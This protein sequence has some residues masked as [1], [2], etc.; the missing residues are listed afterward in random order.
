MFLRHAHIE[1]FR[2]IARLDINFDDTTVL[3]GENAAG[4][5]S[6]LEALEICLGH[7]NQGN[8]FPFEPHD[9]NLAGVSDGDNPPDIRVCVTF[10]ERA[11]GEWDAHPTLATSFVDT[12]A[13]GRQLTLEVS[14]TRGGDEVATS[15]QFLDEH[16]EAMTP[17]PHPDLVAT[18]RNLCPFLLVR[19]DR[20]AAKQMHHETTPPPLQRDPERA[21]ER[22]ISRI[23]DEII[24]SDGLPPAEDLRDGIRNVAKLIAEQA[25]GIFEHP[26]AP[27]LAL[28]ELVERP[29]VFSIGSGPELEPGRH[30]AGAGS[31]AL[32]LLLGAVLEARGPAAAAPGA[33]MILAIEEPE[34]HLHPLML[35]AMWSVIDSLR[36]QKMVTSN[37]GELLSSAR[38]SALRRLVRRVDHTAVFQLGAE[39]LTLDETR[40]VTYHLRLRHDNAL[41]ARA[42]LLV[43]GET[44]VWLL[45]ELA[46]LMGV[47]FPSEG[48]RC[49]EFAQAGIEP[50]LKVANDLGIEWHMMADGDL[51]GALF[52]KTA[53]R[54]LNGS[55]VGDRVTRL[56][57]PDVEHVLWEGGYDYVY[58]SIAR[59][60]S[61]VSRTSGKA[62]GKNPSRVIEQA[63]RNSSKP[64]LALTV[65]EQANESDSPDVPAVLQAT[66]RTV[67]RMARS[68]T[69][70]NPKRADA[71]KKT[72]K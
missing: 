7:H 48:I 33:E 18:L 2:G 65:V 31:V 51:A 55:E 42:W 45:P 23:Y 68:A 10:A 19:A 15:C 60:R 3:I 6:V 30:G 40:K 53:E 49:V 11:K 37:S 57:R 41:F 9:F 67:L 63:V 28:D 58:H 8:A 43:E 12:G 56:G 27:E 59:G 24:A 54:Y 34:L 35:S 5:T 38:L 52:V 50:L 32:L 66:I 47:E 71:Q 17:Q 62:S 25:D 13:A 36:G 46:R 29:V 26:E 21:I 70:A 61:T 20:Y 22:E 69:P 72:K 1:N 64:F 39:T 14:A 4:K 44:E 16:G